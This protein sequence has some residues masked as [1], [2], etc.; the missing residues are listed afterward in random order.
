MSV[1]IREINIRVT[2][3]DDEAGQVSVDNPAASANEHDLEV[4]VNE[5]VGQVLKILRT[6]RER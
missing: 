1:E 5:C 6:D 3:N 4:I 2:V